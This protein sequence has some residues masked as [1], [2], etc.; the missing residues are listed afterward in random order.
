MA[1]PSILPSILKDI[2]AARRR[3]KRDDRRIQPRLRCRGVA[4]VVLLR[5]GRKLPGMLLDLSVGGCC[6]QTDVPIPPIERPS[7]EVQLTVNGI[8]LRVAGIV[9]NMRDDHRAGIEFMDVTPRKADQIIE[10]VK[11][12]IERQQDCRTYLESESKEN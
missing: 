4:E 3:S 9:R 11:E 12:L 7:V 6:I 1:Q 2:G 8:T 10:L 5:L